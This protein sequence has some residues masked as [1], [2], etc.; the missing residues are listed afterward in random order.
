MILLKDTNEIFNLSFQIN[1]QE[2]DKDTIIFDRFIEINRLIYNGSDKDSN[3]DYISF[4]IIVID[5]Q[6]KITEEVEDLNELIDLKYIY[7]KSISPEAV[8]DN[9]LKINEGDLNQRIPKGSQIVLLQIISR[10]ADE[11][12]IK[13]YEFVG[14]PKNIYPLIAKTIRT[15]EY[16][17]TEINKEFYLE[18]SN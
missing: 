14:S 8:S 5:S 13:D 12:I 4:A 3:D 1:F 6:F 17:N 11:E 16:D 15:D 18:F 10:S 7:V 9:C 2:E